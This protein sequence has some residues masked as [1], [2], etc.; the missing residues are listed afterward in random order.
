MDSLPAF[1]TRHALI[2]SVKTR[3]LS[4]VAIPQGT[5]PREQQGGNMKKLLSLVLLTGC[6][7]IPSFA[8]DVVGHSV[9]VAGKDSAKAVTVTAKDSAKAVKAVGKFLF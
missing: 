4:V 1:G 2:P 8:S 5:T 6:L 3:L 9:K 7:A